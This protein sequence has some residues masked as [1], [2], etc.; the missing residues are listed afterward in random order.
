MIIKNR[1]VSAA[2]IVAATSIMVTNSA[3]DFKRP[4]EILPLEL[5]ELEVCEA[6]VIDDEEDTNLL[7]KADGSEVDY[8]SVSGSYS[9]GDEQ[10]ESED[11]PSFY[12]SDQVKDKDY[13]T[14][15]RNQGDTALCWDFAAIGAVES[16]L[17]RHHEGLRVED[18]NLSEKHVAYYNMHKAAGSINGDIDKDY[19]EFVFE[20]D[21]KFLGEYDTSYLSVGGVTDY[22]LSLFTAWKGPVA[23]KD[24]NSFHVIKG[25]NDIYTQNADVPTGAYDDAICHVQNV[26]E[27]PAT[28]KNRDIIKHMIVEHGSVTASVNTSKSFWTGKK[29][30]LYDY[31]KYGEGNYADHE[32]LIVGWNDEYPAKNFVTKPEGDGAFICRNSWGA[33]AGA[34][35]YF[36]LSY[37]DSVLTNNNVVAY[38]AAMPEDDNWYDNNYQYAGFITHV[39]DP[40]VDQKNMVYMYDK[41]DAGYGVT[42]TAVNDEKLEAVGYFSMSTGTEDKLYIYELP[43][44]IPPDIDAKELAD[45]INQLDESNGRG[46]GKALEYIDLDELKKP[47]ITMSCKAVTGGYHTFSLKQPIDIKAGKDYLIVIRPGKKSKLIY[48]KAMD[49]TTAAHRDEWQ[50]NL[51][52]IHTLNTASGHSYLQDVSGTAMI[53]QADKDFFVKVYTNNK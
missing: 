37:Y 11:L 39:M 50:H 27:I 33:K 25:Q 26:Y 6:I 28:E 23:D 1:V 9:D 34:S 41:N 52:A 7:K 18:L 49:S 29:V 13:I 3:F 53:K 20:N 42:I 12:T 22:C 14:T 19:R 32:I 44:R 48:E 40:M 46:K 8:G 30:A 21:D 35:G 4:K 45:T 17:L 38:D 5:S 51:G 15:V 2:Y 16:D 31:K 43:V 47:I 24:T 10:K 36:Y